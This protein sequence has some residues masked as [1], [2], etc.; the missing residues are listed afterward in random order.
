MRIYLN[1]TTYQASIERINRLYD[2]FD[3]IFIWVSGGK[4]STVVFNLAMEVAKQRKQLPLNV[5]YIDQ[6]VEWKETIKQIEN[7]MYDKDVKPFWFQVPFELDNA[8]SYDHKTV[9]CWNEE[10]E[11]D[12]MREKADISYKEHI[13]TGRSIK[14]LLD[15]IPDTLF[16][17][18]SLACLSG[19]RCLESPKRWMGLTASL[20][21]KDITWGKKHP[22]KNHF[23]FYPIYDWSLRDVWKYIYDNNFDYNKIYDY[24][25]RH[26]VKLAN[27]RISYLL[28]EQ[29]MESLFYL[30]EVEP[31]TYNK[32]SIRVHGI[33]S[34]NNLQEQ[35]IPTELPPMFKNW[36]EY[37]DYLMEHLIDEEDKPIFKH[38]FSI[39]KKML[40]EIKDKDFTEPVAQQQIRAIMQNDKT[41]VILNSIGIRLDRRRRGWKHI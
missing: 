8:T 3:E 6:E 11:K 40:S 5:G 1:K 17:K 38:K 30:H 18:K 39:H 23:T 20:T 16:E 22:V 9:I 15:E 27:M 36:V 31:E 7:I 34:A 2:E 35:Y 37:R 41:G 33:N 24:Q 26:G 19:V 21:Y 4:D 13:S 10:K 12:W 32:M 14:K 29:A 28:H 25:F